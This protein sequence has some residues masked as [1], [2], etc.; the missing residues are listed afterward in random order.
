MVSGESAGDVHESKFQILGLK[1][2]L[3]NCSQRRRTCVRVLRLRVCKRTPYGVPDCRQYVHEVFTLSLRPSIPPSLGLSVPDYSSVR[4]AL[5]Q[6]VAVAANG[7]SADCNQFRFRDR[8]QLPLP[9]AQSGPVPANGGPTHRTLTNPGSSCHFADDSGA[10]AL[11][12][13][14][15]PVRVPRPSPRPS[16]GRG[17][18]GAPSHPSR[19]ESP[20]QA[21]C[22]RVPQSAGPGA[23]AGAGAGA[24]VPSLFV[25]LTANGLPRSTAGP[26]VRRA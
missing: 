23:G 6:V 22:R 5:T 24:A 4:A 18:F 7:H 14:E 12:P 2:A 3:S 26:L 16:L 25:N 13:S 10:R 21:T 8:L 17:R 1:E 20:R 11:E 9:V 15:S 19:S